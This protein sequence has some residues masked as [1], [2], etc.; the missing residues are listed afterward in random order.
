MPQETPEKPTWVFETIPEHVF[1][2]LAPERAQIPVRSPSCFPSCLRMLTRAP[3]PREVE[4]AAGSSA[5]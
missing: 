4:E 5:P 3:R 1:P 2:R